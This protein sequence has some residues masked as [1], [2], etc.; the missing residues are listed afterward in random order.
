MK[1]ISEYSATDFLPIDTGEIDH[2][3]SIL[4][5][6]TDPDLRRHV[7]DGTMRSNT[8]LERMQDGLRELIRKNLAEW[9]QPRDKSDFANMTGD[10]GVDP[11]MRAAAAAWCGLGWL[12]SCSDS[13]IRHGRDPE[14]PSLDQ[15]EDWRRLRGN[16]IEVANGLA[17][18][19]VLDE[20]K[21]AENAERRARAMREALKKAEPVLKQMGNKDPSP[22]TDFYLTLIREHREMSNNELAHW[23]F[24]KAPGV[25][26]G[27]SFFYHQ[28]RG[29]L[30][31]R[32]RSTEK[33]KHAITI[34]QLTAQIQKAR[35]NHKAGKKSK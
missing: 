28:S 27:T 21:K 6:E 34:A 23:I 32:S 12:Q 14:A 26:D 10:E 25:D 2:V 15:W 11:W 17:I 19:Q 29:A 8:L 7:L 20:S 24:D 13:I 3:I 30:I 1:P 22:K 18:G 9:R 31:D 5:Q 4:K 35:S 16:L 33:H